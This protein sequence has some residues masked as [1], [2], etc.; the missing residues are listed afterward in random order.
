MHLRKTIV[1]GLSFGLGFVV[2]LLS[3]WAF[4][5]ARIY[6]FP[7]SEQA[8]VVVLPSPTPDLTPATLIIPK[9]NITSAVERVGLTATNNMDVPKDASHVAWYMHG[10]KPSEAGSAVIAGHYDTA[11][12]RPAIF[13]D[14]S[15][16]EKGDELEV[17]SENA[18]RSIFVVTRKDRIAYDT[19]PKEELFTTTSEKQLNLITC[20]GI[21]D[22]KRKTYSERIVVYTILKSSLNEAI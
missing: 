16:L 3:L 19:L 18:V 15:K 2:V 7:V 5:I 11:T 13:Y 21:W 4:S 17:I 10:P 12:G 8:L 22:S 9:L 6:F 20:G 1:F 14:L